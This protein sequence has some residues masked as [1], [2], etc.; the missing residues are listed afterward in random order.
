MARCLI[1]R[2]DV[3]IYQR[4]RLLRRQGP[5]LAGSASRPGAVQ[6]RVRLPKMVTWTALPAG[7]HHAAAGAAARGAGTG[8]VRAIG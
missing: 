1:V 8:R 2:R 3:R 7:A 5:A 4:G 6:P